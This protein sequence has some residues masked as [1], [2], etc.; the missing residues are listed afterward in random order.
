[1]AALKQRVWLLLMSWQQDRPLS[2]WN[3]SAGFRRPFL[4][5]RPQ[6]MLRTILTL[7]VRTDPIS[8]PNLRI[9]LLC[10]LQVVQLPRGVKKLTAP[11]F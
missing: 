11:Q 3:D 5:A 4:V 8:D 9:R 6:I 10:A 7:V 1:M 2:L